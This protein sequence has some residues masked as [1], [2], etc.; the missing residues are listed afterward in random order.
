M[1][2]A[3][4]CGLAFPQLSYPVPSPSPA[5]SHPQPASQKPSLQR[6][7]S[8][9]IS[10]FELGPLRLPV[11]VTRAL[12]EP[13]WPR[14]VSRGC[15][16]LPKPLKVTQLGEL[17]SGLKPALPARHSARCRLGPGM[18]CGW[19]CRLGLRKPLPRPC[20]FWTPGKCSPL[21]CRDQP[22]T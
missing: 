14:W 13:S 4:L 6:C 8:W 10:V 12:G 3:N 19:D 7:A 16:Q 20:A 21:G 22:P 17:L 5:P 1:D 9:N 11:L 18:S 15:K 2:Q